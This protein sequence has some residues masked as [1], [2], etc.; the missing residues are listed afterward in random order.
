[1]LSGLVLT[2][3]VCALMGG[4]AAPLPPPETLVLPTAGVRM[5]NGGTYMSP[6]TQ[7]DVLAGWT[8]KVRNVKIAEQTAM[9][10]AAL[11][12]QLL[13]GNR[14]SRIG[15]AATGMHAA[16]LAAAAAHAAAMKAIGG[17]K[18]I[19]SESDVS[20]YSCDTMAVYM[21]VKYS[22]TEHYG[23]A[24]DAAFTIYP[25]FKRQ[26]RRAVRGALR[27]PQYITQEKR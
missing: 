11:G 8:D 4:C 18:Y 2:V 15:T 16:R 26:Y 22:T 12:T 25:D 27:K 20:F 13:M 19:R 3:S 9:A 17:M 24:L 14:R 21:Y 23:A 1:M 10:V 7:D 6:Y 5:D